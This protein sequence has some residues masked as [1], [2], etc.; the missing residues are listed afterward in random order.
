MSRHNKWSKIKEKK[1]A[2]DAKRGALFSKLARQITIVAK[3]K[4]ADL[5]TN[6]TL[7][8]VVDQAKAASMPKDNIE[9]AISRGASKGEDGVEI[10]EITYEA[11][12]PGGVA[13]LISAVTDN[14]NR[15]TPEIKLLLSKN[16]ASFGGMGSVSWQFEKKGVIRIVGD[17]IKN[18]DEFELEMIDL[19]AEDIKDEEGGL[20]IKTAPEFLQKITEVLEARGLKLEYSGIDFLCGCQN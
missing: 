19:G 10:S 7:R 18:H 13:I 5:A 12:G 4:G 15:T 14:K 9:R 6:F 11:I 2:A 1:G 16:G 17:Q 8:L 3:D 20:T